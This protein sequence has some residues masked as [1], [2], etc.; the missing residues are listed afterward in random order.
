MRRSNVGLRRDSEAQMLFGLFKLIE[1]GQRFAEM[2]VR[3]RMTGR[4]LKRTLEQLACLLVPLAQVQHAAERHQGAERG[5]LQSQRFAEASLRR[6]VVLELA[7]AQ[8]K[9][10]PELRVI[11]V[12]A[13]GALEVWQRF[14][15]APLRC[16]REPQ[17]LTQNSCASE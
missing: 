3:G 10:V 16:Q 6:L 17:E 14:G 7:L 12:I 11:R 8:C 13:H 2:I 4:E 1:P 5:G 9:V 15:E